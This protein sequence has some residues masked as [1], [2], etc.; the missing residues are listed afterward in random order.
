MRTREKRQKRK[1]QM[2]YTAIVVFLLLAL[3]TPFYHYIY[4]TLEKPF[5][6]AYKNTETLKQDSKNI[7]HTWFSKKKILE[8]NSELEKR[9]AILEVDNLRTEYLASLLEKEEIL[10]KINDDAVYGFI[11]KKNND[12]VVTINKGNVDG[13]EKGNF[14]ISYDGSLIGKI[15]DV[16]DYSSIVHLFVKNE[17]EIS[18]I[19]FPQE[20]SVIL[21]GNGNAMFTELNRDVEVNVED[22]VYAQEKP[23]YIIGV[24]SAIDFDPRDPVKRVY[25]SPIHALSSLQQVGVLKK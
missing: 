11:L 9:I 3:F 6:S 15:V 8:Q 13:I 5:I 25:I 24:V 12:G 10:K 14:I 4:D 20:I 7:F 16:F 2:I 22:V 18:A 1:K 21:K 17:T 23:A 19:L